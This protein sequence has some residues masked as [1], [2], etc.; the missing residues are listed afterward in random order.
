MFLKMVTALCLGGMLSTAAL[1]AGGASGGAAWH[2]IRAELYGDRAIDADSAA[3][4]LDVPYRA[5]DDRRVPMRAHVALPAGERIKTLSLIIDENPMPVSAAFEMHAPMGVF[6]T[7][8][9]MRLNGPSPVRALVET[10]GGRL[11]MAEGFVKTSGLGA[12]AAPPL[13][14]IEEALAHL[15]EMSLKPRGF[16][17][18]VAAE[19]LPEA[20]LAIRHPQHSGMQMD[21]I[22]LLYILARYVE[23][24]ETW[25]DDEKLFTVTG[26]IS[27]SEDPDIRFSLPHGEVDELRVRLTD[28]EEAIFERRFGLGAI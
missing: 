14:G 17:E 9:D 4:T 22:T 18:G 25:A 1:A 5:T 13:T 24:I 26:S 20:T 16:G 3:L 19:A 6:A 21:Q 2:E 23:T 27:I 7:E 28:T 12:C 8:I 15:G 11:Y 10:E